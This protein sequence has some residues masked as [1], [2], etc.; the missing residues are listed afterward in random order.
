M[1]KKLKTKVASG[2][3]WNTV[4]KEQKKYEKARTG[5]V[6]APYKR[7]KTTQYKTKSGKKEYSQLSQEE[8]YKVLAARA[9]KRLQRIEKYAAERPEYKEMKKGAYARAIYDIKALR[10]NKR[11]RFSRQ[12][13]VDQNE[14]NAA[15]NAIMKFLVA[16]TST[17]MPGIGTSGVSVER[18]ETMARKFNEGYIDEN[19]D[20]HKG[21][22][23]AYGGEALTWQEI[24]TW[25]GSYNGKRV[26]KLKLGS[27]DAVAIAL[28]QFKKLMKE[29][30]KKTLKQWRE[31]LAKNPE[32]M[33]SD[34]DAADAVMKRMIEH[35]IS[36]R[37]LFKQR[38]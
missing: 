34:D 22:V 5:P 33:L 15:M 26:T 7:K 24:T 11:K 10:G 13:P 9:N 20:V 28:G 6:Y 32:K 31:E 29:E 35:G 4:K 12:M 36:P 25:Y 38:K 3:F 18:Y 30:P 17:L 2:E 27:S 8:E 16:D 19:G 37:N 21:Y 1:S 23:N 14:A